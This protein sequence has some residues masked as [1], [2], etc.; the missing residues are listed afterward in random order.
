MHIWIKTLFLSLVLTWI[1]ETLVFLG[2]GIR[3]KKDL[4]LLFFIN[5][6]TNP[7]A[8]TIYQLQPVHSGFMSW[9]IQIFLEIFVVFTE[10]ILLYKCMAFVSGSQRCFLFVRSSLYS[11]ATLEV[12]NDRRRL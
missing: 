2:M 1:I 6:F 12:E 9:I 11:S 3:K 5:L 10:G 4:L 8:V 7:M